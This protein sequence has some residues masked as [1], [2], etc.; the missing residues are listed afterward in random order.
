MTAILKDSWIKH[1]EIKDVRTKYVIIK[2]CI[3]EIYTYETY[4]FNR[5]INLHLNT[6]DF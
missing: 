6:V 1:F 5:T 3:Y 2:K 4:I